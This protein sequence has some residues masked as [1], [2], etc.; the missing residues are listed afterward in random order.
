[1]RHA[2]MCACLAFYLD[3]KLVHE[4][5]QSSGYRQIS[6]KLLVFES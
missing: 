1:M 3:L 5:I 6:S 4:G 2:G